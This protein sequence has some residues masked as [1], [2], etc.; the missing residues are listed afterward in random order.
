LRIASLA[1]CWDG[2]LAELL[3]A[4]RHRVDESCQFVHCDRYGG[5]EFLTAVF[6]QENDGKR[7]GLYVVTTAEV[8]LF[9]VGGEGCVFL[10][11]G[12]IGLDPG[13]KN[14]DA[15]EIA[16]REIGRVIFQEG[17]LAS[18]LWRTRGRGEEEEDTVVVLEGLERRLGRGGAGEKESG[19]EEGSLGRMFKVHR[20]PPSSAFDGSGADGF[21]VDGSGFDGSGFDRSGRYGTQIET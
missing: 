5:A 11:E 1:G 16:V 18:E 3:L 21:G 14:R 10:T 6:A 8:I 13:G 17:L 15:D 12:G 20:A 7:L 2:A 4:H 19:G 9:R